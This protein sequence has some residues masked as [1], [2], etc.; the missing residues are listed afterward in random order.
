MTATFITAGCL[1]ILLLVLSGW[2]IAARAKY[3][4]GIGDGGNEDM[5]LRVRTHANFVEYV[6]LALVLIMLVETGKIGPAW[7]PAALGGTLVVSRL[8]HAQGLLKSRGVSPGRFIGTNLTF[9]VLL[10]GSGALL[11]RGAGFW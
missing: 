11:G 2:V 10:V 3:G 5:A 4:I 7:L 9:L 6:P 1:G 8:L